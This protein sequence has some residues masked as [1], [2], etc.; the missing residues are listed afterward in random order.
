MPEPKYKIRATFDDEPDQELVFEGDDRQKL[1]DAMRKYKQTT[2]RAF[3]IEGSSIPET[4]VS[5]FQNYFSPPPAAEIPTYRPR[6]WRGGEPGI[7]VLPKATEGEANRNKRRVLRGGAGLVGGGW[8]GALTGTLIG[9]LIDDYTGGGEAP[10]TLGEGTAEVLGGLIPGGLGLAASR[11]MGGT[12]GAKLNA[13]GS[14]AQRSPIITSGGTGLLANLAGAK[15]DNEDPY[16]AVIWGAGGGLLGGLL[17]K[18]AQKVLNSTPGVANERARG[19]ATEK[20][21]TDPLDP[22]YSDPVFQAEQRASLAE[23][24]QNVK[25]AAKHLELGEKVFSPEEQ[26]VETALRIQKAK[27]L[28][29][30]QAGAKVARAQK[31]VRE[32]E[33]GV[34][35]AEGQDKLT[36]RN[37]RR[38]EAVQRL[39]ENKT[40]IALKEQEKEL[41]QRL[42][43][44]NAETPS[45]YN[46]EAGQQLEKEIR[47]NIADQEML[48]LLYT[49]RRAVYQRPGESEQTFRARVTREGAEADLSSAE[50]LKKEIDSIAKKTGGNLEQ[51]EFK[52]RAYAEMGEKVRTETGFNPAKMTPDEKAAAKL[53]AQDSPEE[54]IKDFL[55]NEAK[56]TSRAIGIISLF[57][58]NSTE[59][60]NIRHALISKLFSGSLEE[61]GPFTGRGIDPAKFGKT[62]ES[63]DETAWNA[64]FQNP[65]AFKT[66]RSIQEGLAH[67]A[68][69]RGGAN[70]RFSWT[71]QSMANAISGRNKEYSNTAGL[72]TT[73]MVSAAMRTKQ[74]APQ[75]I[76]AWMEKGN[77]V[78]KAWQK[79]ALNPSVPN[80][81]NMITISQQAQNRRADA[82]EKSKE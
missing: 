62:L 53:L 22:H 20:I 32:A 15:I 78:G 66:L 57:Q 17:A 12:V 29:A 65:E 68:E 11:K 3:S 70:F 37:A 46:Y 25:P 77:P 52:K 51:I 1:A 40:R 5:F 31:A 13:L 28:P 49:K 59:V 75:V 56:S 21:G 23:R 39:E 80:I 41:R 71:P 16:K 18:G 33:I 45:A 30:A 54:F 55:G 6:N 27:T 79:Y 61:S 72:W 10:L 73:A 14:A 34:N 63:L 2:K 64:L 50:A 43:A 67:A 7:P 4:D 8:K 76:D 36:A 19:V 74:I 38:A 82:T 9:D 26:L 44:H 42:A 24:M 48:Q 81:V 58:P 35:A 60:K 47:N 69:G